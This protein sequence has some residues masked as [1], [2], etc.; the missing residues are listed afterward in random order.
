MTTKKD[1]P[2]SLEQSDTV[3]SYNLRNK[4]SKRVT[5][6]KM[7]YTR[8][9]EVDEN[10]E[11]NENEVVEEER[12]S[13]NQIVMT[14]EMFQQLLAGIVQNRAPISPTNVNPCSPAFDGNFVDCKSRFSGCSTEDVAAFI[15]AITVYKQ[16]A[17]VSDTSALLGLS[18]LL[19]GDA[20]T[21]WQG[22]KAGTNNW[23]DAIVALRHA[24]GRVQPSHQIFRELFSK[25]QQKEPTD[26][27]VYKPRH[28]CLNSL[29]QTRQFR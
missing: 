12:M 2:P 25:E 4:N 9:V 8:S 3:H 18:M 5:T 6:S 29:Q 13:V 10:E 7:S 26:I 24:F 16:C 19:D 11:R 15:D 28:C 23:N 21:W 22:A 17:R 27:F 20:A 14:Q 1:V